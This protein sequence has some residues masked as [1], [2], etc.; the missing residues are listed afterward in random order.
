M[1]RL[2]AALIF[3]LISSQA[4]AMN[5]LSELT[6]KKRVVI[7]FGDADDAKVKRQIET[8]IR[9]RLELEERD[10]VVIRVTNDEATAAFGRVAE[11]DAGALRNE[12][13]VKEGSFQVLLVGKDGGIKLRS[14]TVVP[15]VELFDVID[16]MPMRQAERG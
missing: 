13:D 8:L 2:L 3:A 5:S 15:H 12:A 7:V 4:H 14:E 10:L 16:R 6:W 1:T 11:P 9:Q